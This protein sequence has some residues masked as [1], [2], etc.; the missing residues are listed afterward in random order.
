MARVLVV[1]DERGVRESLRMLLADECEVQ[2]AASVDEAL[3]GIRGDAPDLVLLDLVMPGRSGFD[4]LGELSAMPSAPPVLVLTA[5]R[6][7]AT[8]V[9]AMKRG[10]VDYVTKPFEIEELRIKVRRLLERRALESE[11]EELRARVDEPEPVGR[12]LGPTNCRCRSSP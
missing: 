11:V 10:A 12:L 9:E 7:I 5:T 3:A 6:T 1:D 8:A 2:A 4:L